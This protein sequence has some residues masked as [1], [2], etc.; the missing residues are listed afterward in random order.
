MSY[1]PQMVDPHKNPTIKQ[2]TIRHLGSLDVTVHHYTTLD[3]IIHRS[4]LLSI[5]HHN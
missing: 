1:I 4:T 2:V 5:I 3:I